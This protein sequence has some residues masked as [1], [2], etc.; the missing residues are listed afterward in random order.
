[1]IASVLSP[2]YVRP[3]LF[4]PF[5]QRVIYYPHDRNRFI[6]RNRFDV[7]KHMLDKNIGLVSS[8]QCSDSYKHVF[9]SETMCNF[10]VTG[11]AGSYGSGY[12]YPLY[13]YPDE[14]K[15]DIFAETERQYNIAPQLLEQFKVARLCA[16]TAFL[17][18]LCRPA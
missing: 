18:Y 13:L 5:D 3:I 1:V 2:K 10:N 17:L 16:R 12:L 4:R 6:E 9:V 8:R 11:S 15:E 7:M 14:H